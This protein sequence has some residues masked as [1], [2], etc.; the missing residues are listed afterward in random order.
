MKKMAVIWIVS[1]LFSGSV[2]AQTTVDEWT[3]G[4]ANG[5]LFNGL[6]N[7]G[8]P[9]D[10]Q[11]L[12]SKTHAYVTNGVLGFFQ[13]TNG[14][15]NIYL[16]STTPGGIAANATTGAF[17]LAW[18][19]TEAFIAGGDE[20]G[21]SVGF[22]IRSGSADLF[23]IRLQRQ[24]SELLLQTRVGT[25]NTLLYDFNAESITNVDVRAV[26]DLDTDT[27]DVYYDLGA[28]EVQAVDDA[29]LAT[30]GGQ[31]DAIRLAAIM[32]TN[33]AGTSDYVWVDDLRLSSAVSAPPPVSAAVSIDQQFGGTHNNVI[34][35]VTIGTF[36]AQ[37]NDVLV[38]AAAGSN[39]HHVQT[40]ALAW[41]SFDGGVVNTNTLF[42][43]SA[44]GIWYTTVT[45][46]GTFDIQYTKADNYTTVGAYLVRASDGR[47][48]QLDIQGQ[49]LVNDPASTNAAL[50]YSFGAD[51][52]GVAIEVLATGVGAVANFVTEEYFNS[53]PKRITG[54]GSFTNLTSLDT[55]WTVDQTP[56]TANVSLAGIAVYADHVDSGSTPETL[57]NDWTT[58]FSGFTDTAFK[59]NPDADLRDNLSEYALGSDPTI[60]DSEN[61][62]VFQID[63]SGDYFEY[64]HLQRSDAAV[65]GLSY[66]L[67]LTQNLT[68]PDWTN[69][70]YQITGTNLSYGV[71]GF[72]AVT[73]QI[74]IDAGGRQ[75]IRLQIEWAQ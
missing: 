61:R 49:F 45:T 23:L 22:G 12:S 74:S 62:P 39:N 40:N 51:S 44:A 17:E 27:L 34:E 70:N 31:I 9:G 38:F 21:A 73:N 58:N 68:S 69:G 24:N 29:A 57:Y 64:T 55:S 54:S 13:G 4:E 28:G 75:F 60:S 37:T 67:E 32:N 30:T 33:D 8:T 50:L 3:F 2:L 20:T 41:V 6:S 66:Y 63:G 59:S 35:T 16:N 10:A 53:P 42:S 72:D 71:D 46:G 52:V 1:V 47:P 7:S 14:T 43:K 11:W 19:F 5:T 65:R 48:L 18:T 56:T 15:D 36:T 25:V 26:F